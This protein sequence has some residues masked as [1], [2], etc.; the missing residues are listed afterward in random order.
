MTDY[1][2]GQ[3]NGAV[4]INKLCTFHGTRNFDPILKRTSHWSVRSITWLE[5]T[6]LH[7]VPWGS[8]VPLFTPKSSK[9]HE[10]KI[11]SGHVMKAYGGADLQNSPN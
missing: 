10:G 7:L 9:L 8:I 11:V 6:K 2:N 3:L 1:M 5:F 4:I